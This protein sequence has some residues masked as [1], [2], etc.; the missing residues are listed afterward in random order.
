MRVV[1]CA[2][3]MYVKTQTLASFDCTACAVSLVQMV[4]C[5]H[6]EEEHARESQVGSAGT[7]M[8]FSKKKERRKGVIVRF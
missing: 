7:Q 6:I 2:Y 5:R 1:W 4:R 3:V 8:S